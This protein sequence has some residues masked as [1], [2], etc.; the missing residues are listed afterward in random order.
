[1]AS[2]TYD[3]GSKCLTYD[4]MMCINDLAASCDEDVSPIE[5]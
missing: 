5:S 4:P 3:S 1:M 2:M